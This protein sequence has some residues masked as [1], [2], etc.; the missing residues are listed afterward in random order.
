MPTDVVC[1]ENV[2]RY[3]GGNPELVRKFQEIAQSGVCP[4]CDEAA[5]AKFG[6]VNKFVL[7]TK[8]WNVVHDE[9]PYK[10]ARVHL[11]LLPKRH[12]VT[13]EQ[14]MPSE[15]EELPRLLVWSLC[16]FRLTAGYGLALRVGAIGGVTLHHLHF[17]LIVPQVGEKGQIPVNFGIG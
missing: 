7:E 1:M 10:G 17:H 3:Y 9:F 6:A 2:T 16:D 15:W 14:M 8:H 5:K 11:L 4:F 13:L 12:I